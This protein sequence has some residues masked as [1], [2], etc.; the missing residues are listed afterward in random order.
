[1]KCYRCSAA[2]LNEL[3]VPDPCFF[4]SFSRLRE[5]L[6]VVFSGLCLTAM[7]SAARSLL[8][9]AF[10]VTEVKLTS[11]PL[12]AFE[13][14]RLI[15]WLRSSFDCGLEHWIAIDCA[16]LISVNMASAFL[17]SAGEIEVEFFENHFWS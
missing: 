8:R 4:L 15:A 17:N 9:C 1:M 13:P 14:L 7:T 6:F 12:R 2:F 5:R 10:V 3:R 11:V 16:Y